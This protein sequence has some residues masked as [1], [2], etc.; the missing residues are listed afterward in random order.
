MTL[1]SEHQP[2]SNASSSKPTMEP[3]DEEPK[4][5]LQFL[6]YAKADLKRELNLK[7]DD[8]RQKSIICFDLEQI[9]REIRAILTVNE[10][11]HNEIFSRCMVNTK[12]NHRLDISRFEFKSIKRRQTG[13]TIE[14]ISQP[15]VNVHTFDSLPLTQLPSCFDDLVVARYKE[16]P[17]SNFIDFNDCFRK[18]LMLFSEN[19]LG[20]L[21]PKL[22]D[23]LEAVQVCLGEIH[24]W[25]I[26]PTNDLSFIGLD[27]RD[28][29]NIPTKFKDKKCC[30]F[31]GNRLLT[32]EGY[33]GTG[34]CTV[35]RCGEQI[36]LKIFDDNPSY[37]MS[38]DCE[39]DRLMEFVN[40]MSG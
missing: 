14:L 40:F 38:S 21:L 1:T 30:R 19:A 8:D 39:R 26:Q 9:I 13:S 12:H 25:A 3:T 28:V 10:E 35:T 11:I 6:S 23:H 17:Y 16:A 36:V 29:I 5:A 15:E 20:L 27:V 2:K 33:Y 4:D 32:Q 37:S 7:D 34:G 22:K 24:E 18:A 31:C